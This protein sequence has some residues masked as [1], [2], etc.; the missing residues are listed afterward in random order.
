MEQSRS[1]DDMARVAGALSEWLAGSEHAELRDVFLDWIRSTIERATPA[2]EA[3]PV[4]TSLEEARMALEERVKEWPTHWIQQGIEQG[5]EQ[6]RE[7]GRE[8]GI[9]QGRE[10]GIEQ[11]REQGLEHE[12]DLLCRMAA[13]Q[14]GAETGERLAALL[15]DVGEADQLTDVGASLVQ[16]RAGDEFLARVET[17]SGS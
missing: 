14:F 1:P 6:G 13:L 5:I 8:Q 16:C 4:I 17:I 10:Q 3:P 11:G 12:R 15:A 2:G 7:Q 9:E